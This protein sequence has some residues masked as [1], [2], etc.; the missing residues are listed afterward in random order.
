MVYA[1]AGL[2]RLYQRFD[3][4]TIWDQL[5]KRAEPDGKVREQAAKPP[6]RSKKPAPGGGS[7][8]SKW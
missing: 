4:R 7:F 3:R 1:Y 5:E 8:I 2:H 6:L